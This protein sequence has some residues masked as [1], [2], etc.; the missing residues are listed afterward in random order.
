M[1]IPVHDHAMTS[2]QDDS[3]AAVNECI[4]EALDCKHARMEAIYCAIAGI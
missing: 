1:L 3:Q 2:R 4:E